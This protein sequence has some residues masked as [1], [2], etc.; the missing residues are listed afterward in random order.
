VHAA[1]DVPNRKFSKNL[2][3]YDCSLVRVMVW[4]G[5]YIRPMVRVRPGVAAA[6]IQ[7]LHDLVFADKISHTAAGPGAH[8]V[9]AGLL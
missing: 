2:I 6:A 3:S 5:A 7:G 1:S 4:S 8:N 9:Q